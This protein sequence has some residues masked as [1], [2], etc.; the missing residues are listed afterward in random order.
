M[1]VFYGVEQDKNQA[2]PL[3]DPIPGYSGV[4]R[5]IQSDNIFGMT[6]AEARKKAIDSQGRID[7]DKGDTLK[8]T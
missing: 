7:G 4:N 2:L 1:N 3:G 6:Y 8:M 5:R